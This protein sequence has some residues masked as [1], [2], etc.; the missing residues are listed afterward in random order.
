[1]ASRKPQLSADDSAAL[2]RL[3]LAYCLGKGSIS[4]YSRCYVLQIPHPKAHGPYAHYQHRRLAMHMPT[5]K[6]PV[7]QL[8]DANG[9]KGD[10]WRLRC[11]SRWFETAWRLLYD[12]G[13]G[14]RV[15]P[16]ILHLLGAEALGSLWA[17]RGR[18]IMRS[19]GDHCEGRLNLSRYDWA[20][21]DLISSWVQ[22]LTGARSSL[23]HSPASVEMPMLYFDSGNTERLV[24]Q[25]KSTWMGSAD[26]LALKFRLPVRRSGGAG[27][28][29]RMPPLSRAAQPV[30][31]LQQRRIPQEPLTH[32]LDVLNSWIRPAAHSAS[33]VPPAA[34]FADHLRTQ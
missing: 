16:E 17:D 6:E 34:V 9:R 33:P 14:F 30:A 11:G 5:I 7:L 32:D 18:V 31:R 21:A 22:L 19:G 26:C 2:T 4:L 12:N 28:T 3:S 20:S 27:S 13:N 15:T 24:S 10:Q 25:L 29:G 1:M 23:E 8:V